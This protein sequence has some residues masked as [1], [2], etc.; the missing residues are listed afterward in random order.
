LPPS[1]ELEIQRALKKRPGDRHASATAFAMAI[2]AS[3]REDD[4]STIAL[5]ASHTQA[6]QE[7]LGG[8]AEPAPA[9]P[10]PTPSTVGGAAAE[11]RREPSPA[12]AAVPPPASRASNA[13][14]VAALIAILGLGAGLMYYMLGGDQEPAPAAAPPTPEVADVA[15]A[16]PADVVDAEDSDTADSDTNDVDA[17]VEVEVAEDIEVPEV[18]EPAKARP[19]A[20]PKPTSDGP[21][22]E[23]KRDGPAVF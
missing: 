17:E 14:L 10:T 6:L 7:M 8:R 2:R 16:A 20:R 1:L 13:I 15:P 19:K 22:P 11:P 23:P 12:A 5:N 9:R 4:R 3:N 21:K 18:A